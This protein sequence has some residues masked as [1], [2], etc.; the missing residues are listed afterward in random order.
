[1]NAL[2]DRVTAEVAQV[3]VGLEEPVELL[4]AA[5][6][7]GGHVLLEGVP[8]VA[9]TLLANA[10]ARA[11]GISFRRVQFTPDMLPSDLTGTIALQGGELEFRPG[12][13]FTHVLLADEINRTPPKT[14]AALLE[15]MQ[16]RQVTVGGDTHAL[17]APFLVVATQ[18]PIEYEGT[19]PLPEAQ[20]DRFLFKVDVGYPDE[21]R[22][23]ELLRLPH[24]GV[25]PA[26]LDRVS[27][28]AGEDALAEAARAVD[29]VSVEDDVVRYVAGI[30]RRTRDLPSVAL[31]ASPRAAV[32]LLAAAKAAAWL[33]ERAFVTPDDVA[34]MAPPVLRHRL[35]LRPEAELER[36]RPDEAVQA[37]LQAVPVP[38]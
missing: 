5:V 23:L 34:R 2:R 24:R 15:A 12:P 8:G 37:A 20:L 16:E 9:K 7:L 29:A 30:V 11:L 13:V 18:N 17:P 14:Q 21:E 3:A 36:Y 28:V 27:P 38:R 6:A 4:L 1:M 26:S 25:A 31:G 35:I 19:Y 22:E 33:E 10:T 32:H